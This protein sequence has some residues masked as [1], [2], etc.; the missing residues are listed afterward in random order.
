MSRNWP[1]TSE[2]FPDGEILAILTPKS[3]HIPGG[4]GYPAH[5]DQSWDIM[6]Y[7]TETEWSSEII[8]MTASKEDFK[9]VRMTS[10]TIK[11]EITVE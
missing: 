4:H 2:D 8:R 11:T 3:T 1:K 5:T 10:P 7:D 9:A 6:V